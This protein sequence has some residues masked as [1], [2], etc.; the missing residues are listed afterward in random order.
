MFPLCKWFQCSYIIN[1]LKTYRPRCLIGPLNPFV[2]DC[3]IRET[4]QR[5]TVGIAKSAFAHPAAPQLQAPQPIMCCIKAWHWSLQSWKP[6]TSRWQSLPPW[7]NVGTQQPSR[8]RRDPLW[9]HSV[10]ATRDRMQGQRGRR[11]DTQGLTS[12]GSV[13]VWLIWTVLNSES[14][15]AQRKK[16]IHTTQTCLSPGCYPVGSLPVLPEP[17]GRTQAPQR[18]M[19]LPTCFHPPCPRSWTPLCLGPSE[20][21]RWESKWVFS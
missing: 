2:L 8:P 17:A 13:V 10:C 16:M 21:L 18:T 7:S 9:L 1:L 3:G 20:I 19:V 14:L 12:G 5:P 6:V 11:Q 15:Y 4:H